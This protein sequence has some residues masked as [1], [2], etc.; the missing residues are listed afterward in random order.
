MKNMKLLFLLLLFTLT[1]LAQSKPRFPDGRT[2]AVCQECAETLA[3]RPKEVLYGISIVGE[4]VYFTI[5]NKEWLGRLIKED[6]DAI[7]A[8][9]VAKDQYACGKPAP[10]INGYAKGIFLDP[11]YRPALMAKIVDM[12]EGVVS[13]PIGKVPPR[14]KGKELEGNLAILHKGQVCMY[15]FFTDIPRTQWDILPMGLYVD[16]VV[17]YMSY[18]ESDAIRT[19]LLYT[20]ELRF[21]VPFGKGKATMDQARLQ[22]LYDSL[23]LKDYNIQRIDIRAF[24]SVEGPARL[25]TVLQHQR[26][27]SVVM[28]LQPFLRAGVDTHVSYGDDWVELRRDMAAAGF[29]DLSGLSDDEIRSRLANRSWKEKLEPLLKGHRK[30][31]VTLWLAPAGKYEDLRHTDLV[32]RF[33]NAVAK[34]DIP[35]AITLQ[36]D[37]FEQVAAGKAPD[38]YLDKLEIPKEKTY[39][40]LLSNREVYN[41][42][43]NRYDGK[44][45]I[46]NL[47]DILRLSPDNG[48]VKYN[49]CALSLQLWRVDTGFVQPAVLLKDIDALSAMHIPSSLTRR[50]LINYHIVLSEMD[51]ARYNYA[52]KDSSLAYI[53]NNYQDIHLKDEDLLAL[54]KYLCFYQQCEWSENLLRP[55]ITNIDVNEDLLFYYVNLKLTS[56]GPDMDDLTRQVINNAIAIN[57]KRFCRYFNPLGKGGVTFQLLDYPELRSLHCKT[58]GTH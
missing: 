40:I 31:V 14:L 9:L 30:A 23:K 6:D 39:D 32:T 24:S 7:S 46:Q 8:D 4:D 17:N 42:L 35:A 57:P 48:K 55:R 52:G 16:T 54:A 51:M 33:N 15:T 28:A 29:K 41:L 37:L 38:T 25:N 21:T 45:A 53:K 58:C 18:P 12:G 36:R 56:L 34:K 5:S 22:P 50:M 44:V 3:G 11:V 27:R 47:N 2:T 43:L 49:I 20:K 1:G 13:I 10:G 19:P 26:A